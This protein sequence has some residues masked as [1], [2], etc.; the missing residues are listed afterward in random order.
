MGVGGGGRSYTGERV[1][2]ARWGAWGA[3]TAITHV[4]V[5]ALPLYLLCPSVVALGA[6]ARAFQSCGG[7]HVA[8]LPPLPQPNRRCAY[9]S[10]LDSVKYLDPQSLRTDVYH[11]V[12]K[13][14][15]RRVGGVRG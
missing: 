2:P 14:R 1:I 7:G 13:R 9:L 3:W 8:S 15:R 4:A 10:Y 6:L 11:E 5:R 12:R